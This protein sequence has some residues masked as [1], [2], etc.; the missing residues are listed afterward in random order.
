MSRILTI[1][2]RPI[3]TISTA[4][5]CVWEART[6]YTWRATITNELADLI[7]GAV[8]VATP[9]AWH[10]ENDESDVYESIDGDID[11]LTRLMDED[12][13]LPD[14]KQETPLHSTSVDSITVTIN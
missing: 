10:V 7:R 12:T 4:R 14:L 11:I 9:D 2:I 8:A 1:D 13:Q 6:V 5:T 3:T